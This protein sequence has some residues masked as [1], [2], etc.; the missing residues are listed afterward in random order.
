[1]LGRAQA[2]G[3]L[4]PA[5]VEGHIVH[6]AAFAAA[7]Y[8]PDLALDLGAGGGVPGLFLAAVWPETRWVLLDAGRRRTAFL[9]DAVIE[10]GWSDRIVVHRDRAEVAGRDPGLRGRHDLVVARSFG[11]PPVTAECGAPF[12]RVGGRLLVSEPPG[13]TDGTRW[14]DAGLARLGL[15]RG[16]SIVDDDAPATIQT[17]IQ[18]EPCG[19]D[20]PRR[21]GLPAKR[22]LW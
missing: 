15:R 19:D 22:P 5:P 7:A 21:V 2:L 11:P 20:F 16:A 8:P 14:G 9:R 18:A 10:L 4:G 1:M 13:P 3:F 17:L 12:L 6:A